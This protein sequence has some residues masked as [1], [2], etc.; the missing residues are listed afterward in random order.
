MGLAQVYRLQCYGCILQQ[1]YVLG[2]SAGAHAGGA[3]D[4]V[5][6]MEARDRFAH[7]LDYT[8]QL[9]AED[10]VLRLEETEEQAHRER[11]SLAQAHIS[12]DEAFAG[13]T[14]QQ[15]ASIWLRRLLIAPLQR[16]MVRGGEPQ[17]RRERRARTRRGPG[18]HLKTA[19]GSE[20]EGFRDQ[21]R[22]ETR[23]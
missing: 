3:E 8:S 13:V 12:I 10:R 18:S 11:I 1:A 15:R 17:A 6:H 14:Y 2:I 9:M 19:F 23:A 22:R 4:A 21:P 20:P 16:R 5:P 7:G